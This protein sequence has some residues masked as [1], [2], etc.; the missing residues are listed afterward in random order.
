MQVTPWK[1]EE[2][3]SDTLVGVYGTLKRGEGNH[4]LLSTS[5]LVTTSLTP[6][7]YGLVDL[8][9]FPGLIPG[10]DKVVIEVYK[11]NNHTLSRLDSLEGHPTFYE[12]KEV[13]VVVN[14]NTEKVW[15]YHLNRHKDLAPWNLRDVDGNIT[16]GR[17][18]RDF[19]TE[20]QE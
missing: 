6:P 15:V 10:E 7:N 19:S 12:R 18:T 11:V 3:K 8:G 14:G 9:A 13:D 17:H 20:I 5:E 4:R 1:E 16:W 2:K